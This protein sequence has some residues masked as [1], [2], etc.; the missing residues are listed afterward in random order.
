M[1]WNVENISFLH[2]PD[3]F[4]GSF[5]N[6]KMQARHEQQMQQKLKEITAAVDQE[7]D[8]FQAMK[9]LNNRD[10]I[11]F[12]RNNFEEFQLACKLEEAVLA[13][14]SRFNAP[15]SSG[16]DLTVWYDLFGLCDVTR[17]LRFGDPV[18]FTTATLYRG[19]VSGTKRSLSW[20]P[21]RVRA[22]W[23]AERWGDPSLGG[24]KLYEVD[25]GRNDILIYRKRH[26]EDEILLAPKFIKSAEI[27]DF[28]VGH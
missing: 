8:P 24:G 18:S 3:I 23:F 25:V 11:Q 21:S 22:E 1:R 12:L 5:D 20:T 2:Q 6:S 15:F 28:K 14:Y 13:L 26:S 27:K 4:T 10:H 7:T 19:S 16:G 17:L 9:R